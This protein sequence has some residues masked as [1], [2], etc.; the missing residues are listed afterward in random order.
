MYDT[1]LALGRFAARMIPGFRRAVK[2]V[3][4]PFGSLMFAGAY[5]NARKNG[6]VRL[7]VGAGNNRLD[8]WL[9]TDILPHLSPLFLDATHSFPVKDGTVAYIFSEHFIEHVPREAAYRFFRESIR[10]LKPEGVLRVSTPDAEALAKA[11]LNNTEQ[12][13]LLNERNRRM[14][15]PYNSYPIDILNTAFK[16]DLHVCLYDAQTLE[17]LLRQAGFERI[18]H[19]KVGESSH[20]ALSKIEHH[21]VETI[22]D[23]FTLVMEATKSLSEKQV[24]RVEHKQNEQKINNIFTLIC[25]DCRETLVDSTSCPKCGKTYVWLRGGKLIRFR[26]ESYDFYRGCY[27]ELWK[28][29]LHP[30]LPLINILLSVRERVSISTR[31]ERFFRSHLTGN[32]DLLILDVAC[33]YGRKLFKQYGRVIGLDIVAEPLY[34]TSELYDLCVLAD[35][36]SMPFP[37]EYFD[38]IVSSDFL[39]HIP[40]EQKRD[41]YREFRRVLKLGGRMLH[42][43]ETDANNWHFRFAHRY[44][45]LFRK[46]FVEGIG[47]HFGLEL[48]SQA[49][50]RFE[51]NGFKVLEVSK[52]W[53]DIW[54]IQEYRLMFDNEFKDK[55]KLI[56]A[57]VILSYLAGVNVMVQELANIAVNPLSAV[58]ER[59]TPLDNGQGLMVVCQK[60]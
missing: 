53:G 58:V 33:G 18:T 6:D 20:A 1:V 48:P 7:H 15:Y 50:A 14:G 60:V 32:K 55:S 26:A 45:D 46:Y 10:V 31:R 13:V 11:Y 51:A 57:L 8:G 22:E 24:D 36:F 34:S 42:V 3:W 9:N 23:E 59:L 4:C 2:I 21:Q 35:A 37:D 27:E 17:Q 29:S 56:K 38:C 49:V 28:P 25:P 44:P 5:R 43:M 12:A 52:I 54:Q 47:G 40:L 41:L 30:S 16:E 39:G 19:C